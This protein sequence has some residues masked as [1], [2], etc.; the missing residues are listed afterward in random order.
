MSDH[1]GWANPGPAG[2][3]A[4]AI[5]CFCFYA[6]LAGKV[7]HTAIPLLG[8]WLLG[9]FVVQIIVGVMEMLEGNTTGGN[10]F[11]VFAAF[12]MLAGG[13]EFF[14][15]YFASVHG[16]ALDAHID[17]YA[18][19]ALAIALLLFT[20]AYLKSPLIL[21]LAIF[22]LDIAVPLIALMDL[23]LIAHTWAIVAANL[24]GFTGLCGLYVAGAIV[25]NTAYG[26][27]ILPM[28]GPIV[29][30]KPVA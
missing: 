2:L 28:P 9:G 19:S 11:T 29:K 15:K 12:F 8:C 1:K 7:E 6:L 3:V 14:L 25:W 27:Q 16:L 18:W 5:A 30:E 13:L 26:R 4:L 23:G 22:A 20:P 21:S 17:G 10:V 24:L